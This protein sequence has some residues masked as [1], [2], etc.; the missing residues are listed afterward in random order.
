M[1]TNA[2]SPARCVHPAL[3]AQSLPLLFSFRRCPYAMRARLALRISGVAHEVTEVRLREKPAA[4]LAASPKATVPVLVLPMGAV[5]EESLEI[6]HWALAQHDPE[7]WQAGADAAL[8]AENDGAFKFH[9]DR[10]KYPNRYDV[11]PL[12]HRAAGLAFLAQLEARLASQPNL[13][14]A[15]RSLTDM[16][17]VPFVRQFAR[18]DAAWFAAQA[19]PHTQHWLATHLASPLFEAIMARG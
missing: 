12:A 16:A 10:Y 15:Q 4:L 6:M 19:L 11:E 14:G 13:C 5:L 18:T 8:I 7:H 1:E 9:L 3:G 2:I 17:I